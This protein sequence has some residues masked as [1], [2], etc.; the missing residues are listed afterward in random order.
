MHLPVLIDTIL[1]REEQMM[2]VVKK[3]QTFRIIQKGL[4][5]VIVRILSYGYVVVVSFIV[6]GNRIT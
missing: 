6:G 4:S 1:N 5:K 2:D 3:N